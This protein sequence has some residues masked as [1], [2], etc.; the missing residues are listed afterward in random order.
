MNCDI[1][2]L[3]C[4]KDPGVALRDDKNNYVSDWE[5]YIYIY[6]LKLK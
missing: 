5:I 2:S 6:T 3:Y 1:N 4:F